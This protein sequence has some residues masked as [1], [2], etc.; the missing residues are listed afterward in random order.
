MIEAQAVAQALW[1]A[2][3]PDPVMYKN[4]IVAFQAASRS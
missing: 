3:E 2:I 4:S 1:Q